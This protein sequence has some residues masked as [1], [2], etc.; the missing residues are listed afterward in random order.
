VSKLASSPQREFSHFF[1]FAQ[2]RQRRAKNLAPSIS[3]CH[4]FS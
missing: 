3:H 2:L 1:F 4:R